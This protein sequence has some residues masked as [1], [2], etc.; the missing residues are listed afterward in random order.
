MFHEVALLGKRGVVG[1]HRGAY[2]HGM[3]LL[4]ASMKCVLRLW[5]PPVEGLK[6]WRN[7]LRFGHRT[8]LAAEVSP[9][10]GTFKKQ[11]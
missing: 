6:I 1:L 3:D 10:T 7:R 8:D 2:S 5:C 9:C 4:D 11:A